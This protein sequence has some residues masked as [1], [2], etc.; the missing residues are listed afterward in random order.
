MLW[1]EKDCYRLEKFLKIKI[2]ESVC[3]FDSLSKKKGKNFL[4]AKLG[5]DCLHGTFSF[6]ILLLS[7]DSSFY[8]SP[9]E[10]QSSSTPLG[11]SLQVRIQT[12]RRQ[13]IDPLFHWVAVSQNLNLIHYYY[14][15]FSPVTPFSPQKS[16]STLY[17]RC[18]NRGYLGGLPLRKDLSP[19]LPKSSFA[20][21]GLWYS[22]FGQ[23]RRSSVEYLYR[24]VIPQIWD[25]RTSTAHPV[26]SASIDL[27][28][29]LTT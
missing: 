27:K 20:F 19:S 12:D 28:L 13:P 11:F 22:A 2:S 17:L 29:S 1:N 7:Q 15:H 21:M 10:I 18:R 25:H 4:I 9:G 8:S 16:R 3:N 6:F 24:Q 14:T 26:A 23:R 5:S